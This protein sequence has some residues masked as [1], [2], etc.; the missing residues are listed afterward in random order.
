M[1]K[2]NKPQTSDEE[3]TATPAAVPPPSLPARSPYRPLSR[4]RRQEQPVAPV[5]AVER[6]PSNMVFDASPTTIAAALAMA[7]AEPVEPTLA[8][9]RAG[10]AEVEGDE[11]PADGTEGSAAS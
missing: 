8:W 11:T 7:G 2:P 9:G 3:A 6:P 10:G 1:D 5:P 4:R